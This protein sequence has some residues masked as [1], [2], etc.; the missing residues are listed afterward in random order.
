VISVAYLGDIG[1]DCRRLEVTVLITAY[2]GV[3]ALKPLGKALG[4]NI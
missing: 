4:Y 3:E 1:V 2:T